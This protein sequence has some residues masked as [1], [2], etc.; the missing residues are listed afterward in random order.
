MK[1]CF[2]TPS[3]GAGWRLESASKDG[4]MRSRDDGVR[5]DMC[6]LHLQGATVVSMVVGHHLHWLRNRD[7]TPRLDAKPRPRFSRTIS[8]HALKCR[9][10][11]GESCRRGHWLSATPQWRRRRQG[12]SSRAFSSRVVS[13]NIASRTLPD[14]GRIPG[15]FTTLDAQEF[16]NGTPSTNGLDGSARSRSWPDAMW[17]Q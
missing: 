7:S 16:P 14:D 13:S 11:D 17:Q 6:V 8:S 2:S 1:A 9:R 15:G 3:P 10:G 4:R 12:V 5:A